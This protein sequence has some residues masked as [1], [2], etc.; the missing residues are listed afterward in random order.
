M[1]A[2][3]F[4]SGR[5]QREGMSDDGVTASLSLSL[6]GSSW[7]AAVAMPLDEEMGLS[8]AHASETAFTKSSSSLDRHPNHPTSGWLHRA[9]TA[10]FECLGV[11]SKTF[12]ICRCPTHRQIY[13]PDLQ[14]DSNPL[15]FLSLQ[16]VSKQMSPLPPHH[17]WDP[18]RRPEPRHKV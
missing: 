11:R 12:P 1:S 7:A 5:S 6:G 2:W 4:A 3:A 14:T 16:A 15:P 10:P 18:S 8:Y 17:R 9:M 13:F